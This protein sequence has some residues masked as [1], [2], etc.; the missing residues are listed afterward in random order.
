M[1]KIYDK[2][3]DC[4]YPSQTLF[5]S[6]TIFPMDPLKLFDGLY[7]HNGYGILKDFI[8][9]PIITEV[10]NG[11][12][13]LEFDYAKDGWLN[14]F[15]EEENILKANNNGK[16]QLFRIYFI[17]KSL[18]DIKVLAKHI[19]FDLSDNFVEDTAPTA[20]TGEEALNW[21]LERTQYVHGFTGQSDILTT[22]TARYVRKDLMDVFFNADNSFLNV[23]GGEF[24]FDNF[25]IKLFEQ[26]GTNN[27]LTIRYGKNLT[28]LKATLDFETVATRIMPIGANG[29]LLPEKY[30][31]SPL[32]K[33]YKAPLI[34]K[35]ELK[36]GV[37]EDTTEEQAYEL[38]REEVNKLYS[39]GID[40][41]EVSMKIDFIE[42]SKVYEYKDYSSMETVSLGDTVNIYIEKLNINA[43]ARVV[44]VEYDCLKERIIKVE[45]GNIIPNYVNSQKQDTK[46]INN[47]IENRVRSNEVV[48][49]IN[50]SI[51]I[52]T[53]NADKIKLEGYTTINSAFSVDLDGN[54]SIANDN[55]VIDQ[56]GILVQSGSYK[57][58][59]D[60]I[61]NTI[62]NLDNKINDHSFEILP[63]SGGIDATFFDFNFT[64][65]LNLFMWN[66]V[67]SPRLLT[68]IG[69]GMPAE[70]KH[71]SQCIV[72]NSTNRVQQGLA[73]PLSTQ[74]TI[75]GYV[76][77]G[78]RTTG[79]AAPRITITDYD[80]GA[81][82]LGTQTID[83]TTNSGN[84]NWKRVAQT[85]TTGSNI[86][87]AY[88][89]ITLGS[90]SADYVYWDGMQLVEGDKPCIYSPETQLWRYARGLLPS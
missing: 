36:I 64:E 62:I 55:V 74:H 84:F 75:S 47:E 44:K 4:L 77:R 9:N 19:A 81:S 22:R 26:R 5:P 18:K 10:L 46:V 66:K 11:E 61:E 39:S 2:F 78:Y 21:V 45:L 72:V 20:R 43:T 49:A 69:S 37:D 48:S 80:A 82:V 23:W 76:A 13:I 31:D 6:S 51:E 54:A 50:N 63:S 60:G 32:I 89:I 87:T 27:G 34:R 3:C 1:I 65:S 8:S 40:K 38:M 14:E 28:G 24:E 25:I 73:L 17:D 68:N 56:D 41:P 52:R 12:Y 79:E 29:L 59:E 35:V 53:I 7:E 71:A 86:N 85:F 33:N 30:I 42:L 83:F 90:T 67:G 58:V 88:T 70:A 16:D 15:I 57:L